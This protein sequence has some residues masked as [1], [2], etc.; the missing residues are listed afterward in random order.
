M[1]TDK[2][3]WP[4]IFRMWA[5]WFGIGIASIPAG[6]ILGLLLR[7]GVSSKNSIA[8]ALS[9]GFVLS[10]T[11]WFLIGRLFVIKPVP[12]AIVASSNLVQLTQ[13]TQPQ[14]ALATAIFVV[15]L[16]PIQP[17]QQHG[18]PRMTAASNAIPQL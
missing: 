7:S 1:S 10:L 11:A 4:E 17:P 6:I 2:V 15:S 18:Y 3:F 13:L 12:C 8:I 9:L 16:Y 14:Y 5:Q